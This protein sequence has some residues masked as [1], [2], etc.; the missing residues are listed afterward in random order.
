MTVVS[1]AEAAENKRLIQERDHLRGL[2][3]EFGL[4]LIGWGNGVTASV[5]D[6]PNLR[7][8]AWG[9]PINFDHTEWKWL[10]PLLVEL[11]DRRKG[12]KR[13]AELTPKQKKSLGYR[14]RCVGPVDDKWAYAYQEDVL[15]LLRLLA[16]ATGKPLGEPINW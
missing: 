3:A 13:K 14:L 4:T 1:K 5:K 16:K 6:Q 2:L 12:V 9:G 15:R 11:R 10:E 8:H 7:G